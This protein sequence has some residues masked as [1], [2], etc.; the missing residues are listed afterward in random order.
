MPSSRFCPPRCRRQRPQD[1][2]YCLAT[3]MIVHC[4]VGPSGRRDQI[5]PP[6]CQEEQTPPICVPCTSNE[7]SIVVVNAVVGQRIGKAVPPLPHPFQGVREKGP[8]Q[9]PPSSSL[10]SLWMMRSWAPPASLHLLD[11]SPTSLLESA[12]RFD[13]NKRD[14][15]TSGWSRA[16]LD[17]AGGSHRCRLAC[18]ALGDLAP[19]SR[20]HKKKATKRSSVEPIAIGPEDIDG[21]LS[22]ARRRQRVSEHC[23]TPRR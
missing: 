17:R 9:D 10:L 5:D 13:I 15:Q 1:R 18:Q 19:L 21:R 11:A 2:L 4:P 20:A 23:L 12:R 16:G 3:G 6:P 7:R 14:V 8:R 22:I